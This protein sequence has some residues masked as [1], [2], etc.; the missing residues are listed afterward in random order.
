MTHLTTN[1]NDDNDKARW[2]PVPLEGDRGP[3]ASSRAAADAGEVVNND[4]NTNDDDSSNS[5]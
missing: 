2:M 3:S 5:T 1:D 4:D